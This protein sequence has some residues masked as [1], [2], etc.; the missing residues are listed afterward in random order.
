MCVMYVLLSLVRL[1]F[2]IDISQITNIHI[3][4]VYKYL[5]YE[6]NERFRKL[7][8]SNFFILIKN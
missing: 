7:L 3:K 6:L 1:N 4:N 8:V 2:R 5:K